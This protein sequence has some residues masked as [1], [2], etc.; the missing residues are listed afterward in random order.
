MIS[1][2]PEH[3]EFRELVEPVEVVAL[4]RLRHRIYF[5]EQHYGP[6]KELR[7]DLTAHDARSRLYGVFQDGV[8]VGGVR[9]VF[10]D[11]QALAPVFRALRAVAETEPGPDSHALPSE[12]AFQLV[13]SLGPEHR[14]VDVEIGRLTLDSHVVAP[15]LVQ[16]VTLAILAAV[17]TSCCRLYLYSCATSLAKRYARIASPQFRL[18]THSAPGIASDHFLFPKP[19]V[20]AVAAVDDSPY[21][22][23]IEDYAMRLAHDGVID[24]GA[25][26]PEL[27]R[28]HT[29]HSHAAHTGG[30]AG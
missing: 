25:D 1:K 9:L 6:N 20:A 14:R 11:E 23:V 28:S 2:H 19:T 16:H 15:W 24:L 5:E 30:S 10:R 12:E 8:L 27:H 4:L 21:L 22:N 7:L 13:A 29:H 3:V 26:L 17:R 18:E